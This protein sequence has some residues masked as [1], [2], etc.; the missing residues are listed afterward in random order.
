MTQKLNFGSIM[1]TP[2][3]HPGC[4]AQAKHHLATEDGWER[5]C[6]EHA[7]EHES[8]TAEN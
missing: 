3:Q 8:C 2:C 1:A 6:N 4:K 7:K 5:Y